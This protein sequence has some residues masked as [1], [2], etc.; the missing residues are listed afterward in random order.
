MC[1]RS[2]HYFPLLKWSLNLIRELL[3]TNITWVTTLQSSCLAIMT[4]TFLNHA[5]ISTVLYHSSNISIVQIQTRGWFDVADFL[6]RQEGILQTFFPCL[7]ASEI[8][9]LSGLLG[10]PNSQECFVLVSDVIFEFLVLW[11]VVASIFPPLYDA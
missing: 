7:I 4:L 5:R 6:L 3:V 11:A 2:E 8:T 10:E 9:F 1:C